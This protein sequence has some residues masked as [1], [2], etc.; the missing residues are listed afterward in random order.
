[1]AGPERILV[2]LPNWLGDALLARP[3]LHGLERTHPAAEV[4]GVGP[5]ALVELLLADGALSGGDAW[6][7]DGP[8]RAALARGVRAWRPDAALVLPTS[9]S[10]ALFAWRSGAPLRVGYRGDGRRLLLTHALPRRDR[11]ELHLSREFLGLGAVLGVEE[12]PLPA[13]GVGER[14]RVA[15]KALLARHGVE[16]GARVALLGPRSAWG[17]AREWPAA[18]FAGVGRGLAARGF[19]VVVCGT[20]AEGESCA[21]VA[22]AAGSAAVSLAGETDLPT[23]AALCADAALAVCNDSGLAHVAAAA[24]AATVQIYGSA[25]SAWTAAL[26]PRVRVVQR[27]PV[28]S[29]CYQRTCRIGTRCLTGIAAAEVLRACDE[30]AA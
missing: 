17:P 4:R 6:P 28:C 18:C 16:R 24:G 2:R 27:P 21:E 1:M 12:A 26:G 23:L 14:A 19:R 11:G 5:A 22:A 7:P 13:L 29:P 20:G 8:G 3:L 9:F 15:A 10:S 30:M 25:S